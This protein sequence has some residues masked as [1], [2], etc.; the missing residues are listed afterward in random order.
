MSCARSLPR[1]QGTGKNK[2]PQPPINGR[3]RPQVKPT[4]F[5]QSALHKLAQPL[6]AA[7]WMN[8]LRESG[9]VSTAELN[10][11][12][13]L[14]RAVR[15]VQFLREILEDSPRRCAISVKELLE[16]KLRGCKLAHSKLLLLAGASAR[17][18]PAKRL[19]CWADPESLDRT[20]N[21]VLEF[22]ACAAIPNGTLE[23]SVQLMGGQAVQIRFAVPSKHGKRLAE[24]FAAEAH[25]FKGQGFFFAGGEPPEAARINVLVERMGG[26]IAA[27]GS[28]LE[29]VLVLRLALAE[30]R[31][32]LG[33][34]PVNRVKEDIV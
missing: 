3:N 27:E 14:N 9:T 30:R 4:A 20:L 16:S 15:M 25:P 6:T 31:S 10:I 23:V 19:H 34:T 5:L 13:E 1:R 22:L 11:G 2:R 7:L 26:S 29:L 24:E 32:K 28:P 21:F 18:K 8:E 33:T 17:C 12:A